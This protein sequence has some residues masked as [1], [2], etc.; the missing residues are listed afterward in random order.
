MTKINTELEIERIDQVEALEALKEDWNSLLDNNETK[1]IELSYEWQITYWKNFNRNSEL[2]VLVV[3][4]AGAVVAIAPLRLT[5]I[6]KFGIKI[7]MLE[8][9]ASKESNYQDFLIRNNNSEVLKCILNYLISNKHL[10]DILRLT[11]L[12]VS[13]STAHFF[14]NKLD[15]SSLSR[16]TNI[17]KCIFLKFDKDW[18]E[19][20]ENLKKSKSKIAY[21]M[22]RLR[23]LGEID[24]F[25]CSNEE[26][27]RSNLITLF[28]LHRK[29]WNKTKTPSNFNDKRYCNFYLE[30]IPQ[31]LSK[32]QIDLFVLQLGGTPIAFLYSFRYKGN[33]LIQLVTHDTAYSKGAPSLILHELFVKQAFEDGVEMVDFGDYYPYKKYWANLFKD[34]LNIEI[35]P[36][37]VLPYTIYFIKPALDSIRRNIFRK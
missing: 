36:K 15:D 14:Q 2:Y 32:K 8:F 30:I 21:R 5:F 19:Y 33:Y 18:E 12:P 31:L 20:I 35:Y 22:K 3:R 7:R 17:E 9:I 26:Q 11:K 10:W 34:K 16:I 37:K 28:E 4:D 25:H 1:T 29:R 6:K 27:F 13:S 23:R 24:Y